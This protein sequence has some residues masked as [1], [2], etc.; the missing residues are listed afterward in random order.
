MAHF[1]SQ[2]CT[3]ITSKER[4]GTLKEALGTMVWKLCYYKHRETN[5]M[6]IQH[7]AQQSL[8]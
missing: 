1:H 2:T 5:R 8:K 4:A 7:G 3:D 6:Y